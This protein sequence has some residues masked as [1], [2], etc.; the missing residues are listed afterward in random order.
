MGFFLI[1]LGSGVLPRK[2]LLLPLLF[3]YVFLLFLFRF[4]VL[5]LPKCM[6]Y[7]LRGSFVV[8]SV[9]P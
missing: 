1:G 5:L 2:N 7:A 9:S 4:S 6:L 8:F 3:L